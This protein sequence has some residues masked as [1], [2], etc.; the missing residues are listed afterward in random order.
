MTLLQLAVDDAGGGFA[1]DAAEDDG[2]L[3]HAGEGEAG[4]FDEVGG[5]DGDQADAHVEGA[6]HLVVIEAA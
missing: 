1:D 6:E 4:F 5:D 3:V 2:A